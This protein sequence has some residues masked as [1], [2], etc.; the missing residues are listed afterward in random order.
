MDRTSLIHNILHTLGLLVYYI[1]HFTVLYWFT[2]KILFDIF[3]YYV[4]IHKSKEL[5][6][7]VRESNSVES[8]RK[9]LCLTDLTCWLGRVLNKRILIA[10]KW[11]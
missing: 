2:E 8:G 11:K 7:T 10:I 3:I 9:Y 4:K 5:N 6:S 1:R